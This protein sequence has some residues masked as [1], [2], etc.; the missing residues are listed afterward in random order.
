MLN[1]V[2]I[3]CDDKYVNYEWNS[4][5]DFVADMD[6]DNEIIP[7]L[8]DTLAEVNTDDDALHMWWR[9]TGYHTVNDLYKKCKYDLEST[10][11]KDDRDL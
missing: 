1:I 4:L 9:D 10:M 8:D 7:M 11:N 5:E 3:N 2:V 6:S